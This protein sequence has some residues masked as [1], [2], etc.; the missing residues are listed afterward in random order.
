M[1]NIVVPEYE[2]NSL[3]TLG[4]DWLLHVAKGATVSAATW[5]LV[6]GQ[7]GSTFSMEANE[8]D[9]GDKTT[10]GWGST[11]AGIKSWSI[12]LESM[13]VLNNEGAAILKQQFLASEK[14]YVLFRHKDGEAYKGWVSISGY[15]VDTPHD[16]VAGLTCTLNGVG[17]PIITDN[18]P[19]PLVP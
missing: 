6:G 14:A 8:I 11:D 18:E 13:A 19:D 4:K 3:H 10:G 16:D 1:A 9:T 15:E 7:R 12:E 17:A 2:S 5:V